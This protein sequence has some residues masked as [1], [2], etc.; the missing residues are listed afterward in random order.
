MSH[1]NKTE[2]SDP[3]FN[4]LHAAFN[5]EGKCLYEDYVLIEEVIKSIK[6]YR[7]RHNNFLGLRLLCRLL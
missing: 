1:T 4:R 2:I 3:N 6:A 7:N 5:V